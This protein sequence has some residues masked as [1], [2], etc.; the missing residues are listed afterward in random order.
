M[1]VEIEKLKKQRRV[2]KIEALVQTQ[3]NN[4]KIK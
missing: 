4:N 1:M 2:N 3:R